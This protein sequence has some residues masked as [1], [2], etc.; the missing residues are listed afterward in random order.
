VV[1][2]APLR[3]QRFVA[4]E[5][6]VPAVKEYAPAWEVERWQ[7]LGPV[8]AWINAR[9][10]WSADHG[11]ALGNPLERIRLER[12]VRRAHYSKVKGTCDG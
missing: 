10:V 8:H 5:W 11:D 9:R 7:V 1:V 3:L 12:A 2:N 6:A 4:E